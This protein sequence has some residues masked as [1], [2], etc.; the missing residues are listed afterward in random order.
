MTIGLEENRSSGEAATLHRD[1]LG[2]SGDFYLHF[3]HP[4]PL[5]HNGKQKQ[6][7]RATWKPIQRE[8]I[9]KFHKDENRTA[10]TELEMVAHPLSLSHPNVVETYVVGSAPQ[11]F[12][13][14]REVTP[15]HNKWTL[16][17]MDE[18]VT[19]LCHIARALSFLK[20]KSYIHADIKPENLGLDRD[21]FI[22]MDFGV[23]KKLDKFDPAT[24]EAGTIRTR[25]PEVLAKSSPRSHKSD[26]WSLGASLFRLFTQRFPLILDGE[27][28]QLNQD[29]TTASDRLRETIKQRAKDGNLWSSCFWVHECW[30]KVPSRLEPLMRKMLERDPGK[31]IDPE[32]VVQH[33]EEEFAPYLLEDLPAAP[34]M[35]ASQKEMLSVLRS[36]R[37]GKAGGGFKASLNSLPLLTRQRQTQWLRE[38][39]LLNDLSA[40]NRTFIEQQLQELKEVQR[41]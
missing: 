41:P 19:L 15:L 8:V 38:L 17:G 28:E 27:E 20:R 37:A 31:R 39:L 36:L 24:D 5:G 32:G 11:V 13:V 25:A 1:A 16:H 3:E 30:S 35:L 14:E 34:V 33:C 12:L 9:V 22:L 18:A 40:D 4:K 7:Y 29:G 21:R 2:L 6:V 23:C 26:L 10:L